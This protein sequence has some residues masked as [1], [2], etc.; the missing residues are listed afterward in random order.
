MIN[1]TLYGLLAEF[2]DPDSLI[3][4]VLRTRE[5]GYRRMD[6]FSP[7]PIEG[8]AEA[9]K[10]TGVSVPRIMLIGG[11]VGGLVGFGL[12]YYVSAIAYPI[13]VGG[14]PI[15][16]WPLFVP[17]IFELIILFAALG[18]AIGM[19]VLNGLPMPYHPVFNVSRFAEATKDGFFMII[20]ARDPKFNYEA[21]R[22][23]LQ[24]LNPRG[25]FDVPA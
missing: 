12:Q 8:L 22:A 2:R 13:N 7:Y 11:I 6:A 14:R 5:A 24:T 19:F 1:Q 15:D 3:R 21:T 23:F 25:V 4:A 17:V 20:E 9:M 10:F 16:S 18:G